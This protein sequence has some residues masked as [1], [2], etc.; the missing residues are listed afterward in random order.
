MTRECLSSSLSPVYY[1]Y[2]Y[3]D[4]RIVPDATNVDDFVGGATGERV[5]IFPVDVERWCLVKVELLL[6]FSIC[7]IP[8]NRRLVNAGRKD[9]FAIPIPFQRKYWPRVP[10]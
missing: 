10:P 3:L 2:N 5:I 9:V 7:R 6:N 4:G 1:S 8:N